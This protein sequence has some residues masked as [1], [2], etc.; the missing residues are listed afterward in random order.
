MTFLG[1]SARRTFLAAGTETYKYADTFMNGLNTLD[2]VPGELKTLASSLISLGYTPEPGPDQYLLNPDVK[3]L[4]LAIRS[5]A[6]S[7]QMAV[8][9]Y[10]GHGLKPDNSSYY[11]LTSDSIAD[12]LVVT[13][14]EVKNVL[15]LLHL[16]DKDQPVDDQPQVLLILDCCYAGAGGTE[17]LQDTLQ[18][19]GGSN[20]WVLAAALDEHEA[21]QELFVRAFAEAL[22]KPNIGN[23]PQYLRLTAIVDQIRDYFSR[24]G[25]VQ[26]PAL[27]F[28]GGQY[29]GIEPRFFPNPG[30]SPDAAGSTSG[31][32]RTW[33]NQLQAAP[34][35]STA[36]GFYVAGVTGRY[37]AIQDLAAWMRAPNDQRLAV[38]TGSPGSGKSTLLALPA[39]L[40]ESQQATHLLAGPHPNSFLTRAATLFDG[41]PVHSWTAHK[42]TFYEAAVWIADQLGRKAK[43]PKE[44]LDALLAQPNETA[45]IIVIDAVDEAVEPARLLNELL[46]PLT[47]L[48]GMRILIGTRR[49]LVPSDDY[50][51]LV[52]DLDADSYRDPQALIAYVRELL[53]A[54]REPVVQSPYTGVPEAITTSVAQA[55]AERATAAS[56]AAGKAE[57][58]LMAQLLA[59]NLRARETALDLTL[60][61]WIRQLPTD[62]GSAFDADLTRTGSQEEKVRALLCAL[63]WAQGP[64]LPWE[65]IWV[66]VAQALAVNSGVTNRTLGDSDVRELLE[67]AGSYVVEDLGPGQT[68]AFR[69]FHELLA[70]HLRGEPDRETVLNNPSAA[71]AWQALSQKTHATIT[72]AL[73]ETIPTKTGG[74]P[75]WEQAHPYIRTYLA[76]HAHAANPQVFARLLTD[77]DYLASADPSTLSPL[78]ST[79]DPALREIT[80]TYRRARPLLGGNAADNAAYLQ[81]AFV[82]TTGKAPAAQR[83]SPSYRSVMASTRRDDS[84]L[85]LK[86]HAQ[87]VESVA[88]GVGV[89]EKLILA[90]AGWE[91][92][93][94]LWDLESGLEARPP[95]DHGS[96]VRCVAFGT[97]DGNM[98]LA[99]GGRDGFVRTWDLDADL[100]VRA[101]RHGEGV[102]SVAFGTVNDQM[103][104]SGGSDGDVRIWD[105]RTGALI[106]TLNNGCQVDALAFGTIENHEPIV[107]AGGSD[108]FVRF[109]DP[110]TGK[111]IRSIEHG[112]EVQTVA[113][114]RTT[115]GLPLLASAGWDGKV[116]LWDALKGALK[117][118]PL[119]GHIGPV[120][121][122]AFAIRADELG[123]LASAGLDGTVRLWNAD[124][125]MQFGELKGHTHQAASVTFG[126]RT[127][128]QLILASGGRDETV[129]IWDPTIEAFDGRHATNYRGSV[130]SV[131]LARGTDGILVLASGGGDDAVQLWDAAT[132]LS[133]KGPLTG[134]GGKVSSVAFGTWTDGRL[135]LASAGGSGT[136]RL[137]DLNRGTKVVLGE[138]LGGVDSLAFGTGTDKRLILAS[139]GGNVGIQLWHIDLGAGASVG[140]HLDGHSGPV[141]S[142]A[143]GTGT[144]GQPILASASWDGTVRLWDPHTGSQIG[145]SLIGHRG[146]VASVAFG[147]RADGQLVLATAGWDGTVRLWDPHTSSQMGDPLIGHEGSVL[148]AAFGADANRQLIV[149][150]SGSDS[151]VRLWDVQTRR[152][153]QVIKRR[154]RAR[155][156]VHAAG[157]IVLGDDEGVFVL[158][159]PY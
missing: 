118:V 141:S 96:S 120:D 127:D 51:G 45:H 2:A 39:T 123:I 76:R 117:G 13:A 20:V 27:F 28:P 30:Y 157:N 124:T 111:L 150:S 24:S 47:R 104:A 67:D 146:Q 77:F 49:H 70:A 50:V 152:P 105:A 154:T 34:E 102:T 98:L 68:S 29:R 52:V 38:V 155:V 122:V 74:H 78:L 134:H 11:V 41:L 25:V 31:E 145:D 16:R 83:I 17:V 36:S 4:E 43:S 101:L 32:Y 108:G 66:P 37:K 149:V 14:L 7:A 88:F 119:I 8:V 148:C 92:T 40:F 109:W 53:L 115:D 57:S 97:A 22:A 128:G 153:L 3:T 136:I 12:E 131:A 130:N 110:I 35:G 61:G 147:T 158:K 133:V 23:A 18:G 62:V 135:I 87:P 106:R 85:T 75:D 72:G 99:S 9:Y 138:H 126:T 86:G 71:R 114:G 142:V 54:S 89:D 1:D 129:R 156:V 84:L 65:N 103:L 116:K 21:Q 132:G 81:E 112:C 73:L 33:A 58:F 56:S 113:F 94:R 139:A 19:L 144:D 44:L 48:S 79:A 90:S 95:L 121:S 100:E 140:K 63:A 151:T 107:A 15:R 60:P 143:F 125:G 64:G 80:L 55:I 93:V 42:K 6:R 46:L 59:R 69:P 91:S 82:A 5:L 137:W 26:K 159:T 10:T